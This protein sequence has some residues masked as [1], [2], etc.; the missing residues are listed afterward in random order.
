MTT[1][2]RA[3]FLDALVHSLP[4]GCAHFSKKC[5][6]YEYDSSNECV[7]IKFEDGTEATADVLI[8]CDGIGS[9]IRKQMYQEEAERTG[10]PS[11]LQF[12]NPIWSGRLV[13]RLLFSAETLKATS[14]LHRVLI[15]P[16]M[17]RVFVHILK[18]Y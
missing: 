13:Y 17:V 12:V 6:S 1:F 15:T 4:D 7:N 9:I 2:H 5:V 10:D 16:Q 18:T 8:A 3:Q 11:F 14:P